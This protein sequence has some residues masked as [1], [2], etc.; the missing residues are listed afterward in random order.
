MLMTLTYDVITIN[1]QKSACYGAV[2]VEEE[3]LLACVK[4][5][6]PRHFTALSSDKVTGDS[7]GPLATIDSEPRQARKGATVVIDSGAE[8]WLFE[9]PPITVGLQNGLSSSCA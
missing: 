9:S 3:N 8:V 4:F 7:D 1:I 2:K 6:N 5:A